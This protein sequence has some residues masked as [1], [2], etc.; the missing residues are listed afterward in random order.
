MRKLGNCYMNGWNVR[1][2]LLKA[3][4][5]FRKAA[6]LGDVRSVNNLG[7]RFS[8]EQK[9]DKAFKWFQEAANLGSEHG[10]CNLANG[11]F[12]GTFL[13]QDFAMAFKWLRQAAD[14][15]SPEAMHSLGHYYEYGDGIEKDT[16]RGGTQEC[17]GDVRHGCMATIRIPA[18]DN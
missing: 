9:M 6:K 2:D 14:H 1:R 13:T 5:W 18:N 3:E 15:G 12:H 7:I 17:D 8:Q 10:M 11:Y 4:T 16:A